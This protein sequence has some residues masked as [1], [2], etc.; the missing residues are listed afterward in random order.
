MGT[1]IEIFEPTNQEPLYAFWTAL[2]VAGACIAGLVYMLRATMERIGRNRQLLIAMLLFF[3]A[4]LAGG[5]AF[6]SWLTSDKVGT[7]TLYKQGVSTP[8][9]SVRYESIIRTGISLNKQNTLFQA[10]DKKLLIIE[11][12][13]GKAH[14][15]SEANYPIEQLLGALRNA[16]EKAENN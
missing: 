5:S 10:A 7:V 4:M 15:L 8:Y 16:Q 2:V 9:G 13:S 12:R 11:E 6:L 1:V 3:G 14:V